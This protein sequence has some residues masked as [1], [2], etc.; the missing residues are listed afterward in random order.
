MSDAGERVFPLYK[1]R[2]VPLVAALSILATWAS[3]GLGLLAYLALGPIVGVAVGVAAL[4]MAFDRLMLTG[5]GWLRRRLARRLR[6]LGEP[7]ETGRDRFV[8]LAHPC[9]LDSYD[10]RMIETDDDVGFLTIAWDG[11]H[12]H[13]DGLE[14]VIPRGDILDVRLVRS[15]HA[16]WARVEVSIAGGEPF[17]ALIFD[18]REHN[19]HRACR[20]DTRRLYHELLALLEPSRRVRLLP[21]SLE[22]TAKVRVD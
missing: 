7:A 18:S 10:R 15:F 5:N 17:D 1:R 22:E 2:C 8:G 13:G 9:H 11:I 4:A 12:F 21:E 3:A 19:S 20:R 6:A 16:P 14:F